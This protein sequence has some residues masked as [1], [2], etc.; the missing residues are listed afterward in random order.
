[1][2]DN[3]AEIKWQGW[4]IVGLIGSGSFGKV[5][6]IQR[7]MFGETEKAALKVITI[8]KDGNDVEEL[9]SEGYDEESIKSKYEDHLKGIVAEYSMMRKLSSCNNVVKCED[10]HYEPVKDGFGWHVFIRMELLT[11]L[12]KVSTDKLSEEDIIKLA[13]DLCTALIACKKYN[14]IHRDIKPQNIFISSAGD[15]KLGDFGVAKVAEK[16]MFGTFAGTEKFMA[17]EVYFKKPYGASADIY[18]LGLN[19]YWLLNNRRMPFIPT[20]T[21]TITFSMEEDAKNRRLSGEDLPMPL[22]GSEQ[23]KKIVLKACAF[24]PDDR[25]STAQEMLDALNQINKKDPKQDLVDLMNKSDNGDPSAMLSLLNYYCFEMHKNQSGIDLSN[26]KTAIQNLQQ[27]LLHDLS[28]IAEGALSFLRSEIQT[29][30]YGVQTIETDVLWKSVR[31]YIWTTSSSSLSKN[32]IIAEEKKK[33]KLCYAEKDYM[34]SAEHCLNILSFDNKD[35]MALNFLGHCYS[36]MHYQNEAIECYQKVL[37]L[38]PLHITAY[39]NIASVRKQSD[40]KKKRSKG[41][42]HKIPIIRTLIVAFLI[43][44]MMLGGILFSY[45]SASDRLMNEYYLFCAEK[46]LEKFELGAAL[47]TYRKINDKS[48]AEDFYSDLCYAYGH[49]FHVDK[50]YEK[51]LEWLNR[52]KKEY[53]NYNDVKELINASK[54]SYIQTHMNNENQKTF[55]YLK[56]LKTEKY[57]DAA[58][59]YDSLYSWKAQIIINDS[60]T[61]RL[62]NLTTFHRTDKVLHVHIILS[63]GEP[64]AQTKLSYS[65]TDSRGEIYNDESQKSFISGNDEWLLSWEVPPLGKITVKIYDENHRLI[66][67]K[68]VNVTE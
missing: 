60:K 52:I 27:L 47:E 64:E 17:P 25:F 40:I 28:N 51:A 36:K 62:T 21:K 68:S 46:Q 29:D 19:L 15:F 10:V 35:F 58:K 55:N 31:A 54:Y 9:Y 6:E 32:D 65:I 18:S 8:P 23:L 24:D 43:L 30:N 4:E 48:I 50:N 61:D 2:I 57:S 26:D 45:S 7:D 59:I 38:K 22:H 34:S 63:G 44:A 14:I 13:K 67:E 37:K 5:Y 33:L 12:S 20:D 1:M 41:K 16:T 56:E 39:K 11:A 49:K 42:V 53:A 66:G 3:T